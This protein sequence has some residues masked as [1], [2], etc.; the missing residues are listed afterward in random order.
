VLWTGMSHCQP[1]F[2]LACSAELSNDGSYLLQ[3]ETNQSGTQIAISQS[4]HSIQL[5]SADAAGQSLRLTATLGARGGQRSSM[6]TARISDIQFSPS[7]PNILLSC[8]EDKLVCLWDTRSGQRAAGGWRVTAE[9][10]AL[11]VGATGR[12]V[13]VA[14]EAPVNSSDDAPIIS[15][16]DLTAGKLVRQYE[17]FHSDSVSKLRWHPLK[18]RMLCSASEDGLLCAIDAANPDPDDALQWCCNVDTPIRTFDFFGPQAQCASILTCNE[19]LQLCR[20][21]EDVLQASCKVAPTR[22]GSPAL[23]LT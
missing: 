18:T 20:L 3:S 10:A 13:A 22:R 7:N 4:N 11:A 19:G 6:H 15:L 16:W 8:G 17:D 23:H 14:T 9:A 5:L 1:P 2:Q 21:G 12:A